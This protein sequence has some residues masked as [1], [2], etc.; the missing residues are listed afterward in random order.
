MKEDEILAL[1]KKML[2]LKEACDEPEGS[3]GGEGSEGSKLCCERLDDVLTLEEVA[4]MLRVGSRAIYGWMKEGLPYYRLGNGKN[5][6]IRF[7]E[8]EVVSW[9]KRQRSKVCYTKE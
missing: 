4:S 8:G 9:I 1:A 6:P 3:E 2:E 7:F 5:R